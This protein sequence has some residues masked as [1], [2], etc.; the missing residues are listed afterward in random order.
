M[1]LVSTVGVYRWCLP[2]ALAV[3]ACRWRDFQMRRKYSQ[4][5]SLPQAPRDT[6]IITTTFPAAR[7]RGFAG[8]PVAIAITVRL[9]LCPPKPSASL[10]PGASRHPFTWPWAAMGSGGHSLQP[11]SFRFDCIDSPECALSPAA[12][13]PRRSNCCPRSRLCHPPA[14][15]PTPL[16]A[17][18]PAPSL[19]CHP[20]HTSPHTSPCSLLCHPSPHSLPAPRPALSF[21]ILPHL[22]PH[23]LLCP[24]LPH[25]IG[26]PVR[27]VPLRLLLPLPE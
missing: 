22:S 2:L 6:A 20:S 24:S 10:H 17:P 8:T 16:P 27:K 23:P 14:P 12:A 21:V 5:I 18:L 13:T 19:L 9:R 25:Y 11:S 26:E 3:G 7:P 4:I 15:L 1:A